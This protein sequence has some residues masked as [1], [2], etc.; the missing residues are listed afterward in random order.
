MT[1]VGSRDPLTGVG[2]VLAATACRHGVDF[3]ASTTGVAAH[4]AWT[5]AGW[6]PLSGNWIESV[7]QSFADGRSIDGR[8]PLTPWSVVAWDGSAGLLRAYCEGGSGPGLLWWHDR[9]DRLVIGSHPGPVVARAGSA[10]ELDPRYLLGH[11]M[12]HDPPGWTPYRGIHRLPPGWELQWRPGTAPSLRRW[13][14]PEL[15][16]V[17]GSRNLDDSIDLYLDALDSAVSAH[18]PETGDVAAAMSAGLDSTMVVASAAQLLAGSGRRVRSFVSAPVPGSV[19][20]GHGNWDNDEAPLARSFASSVGGVDVET[21]LNV[22]H[23]LDI[24]L[25]DERAERT[26]LPSHSSRNAVW[27]TEIM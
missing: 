24:D 17:S 9:L 5:A 19:G 11:L 18:L 21:V 23:E 2:P 16:E 22:R 8:G 27:F 13:W 25:A 4:G 6:S 20:P 10:T 26:W 3:H 7:C 12:L 15:I 14:R 1:A